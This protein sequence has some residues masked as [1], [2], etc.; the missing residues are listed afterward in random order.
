MPPVIATSLVWF[1][2]ASL[3]TPIETK[4]V[5]RKKPLIVGVFAIKCCMGEFISRLRMQMGEALWHF[6]L[7]AQGLYFRGSIDG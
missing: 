1:G 7:K 4:Q 2:V 3:E 6:K 5:I